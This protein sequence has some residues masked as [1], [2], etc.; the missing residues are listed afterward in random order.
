MNL[1]I[2]ST[3]I[4]LCGFTILK[5]DTY[6]I[7]FDVSMGKNDKVMGQHFEAL[8]KQFNNSDTKW[9]EW[10]SYEKSPPKNPDA[11][12][13]LLKETYNNYRQEIFNKHKMQTGPGH[14]N[15]RIPKIFHQ[16]WVGPNPFPE[17][18]KRWQKTW[19]SIPG[20]Q[21][22]L[23]TDK[24]VEN[25]PLIN[26]AAYNQETNF[27][28]RADILRLEI[29][30]R[31]GGVYIDTDFE[32][33]K[34]AMFNIL[35]SCYDFYCGLHPLDCKAVLL[36]NAL[37]GAIPG[38]PIIKACIDHIPFAV[39]SS[40][41]RAQQIMQRGPG[42]IS[43]MAMKNMN[44]GYRDIIFPAT[45][46]YPLGLFEMK[47]KPYSLMPFND[48]TLE[49]I[50][51]DVIKPETIAIHWWDGSWTLPSAKLQKPKSEAEKKS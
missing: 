7:D 30:Y 39:N 2:T 21:Y 26:Q 43:K 6:L 44:K 36:N 34:P 33:V 1:K 10:L 23:W 50:K 22:K 3:L 24:E 41:P 40:S 19:Q 31:E 47:N 13:S 15:D 28:A 46:F 4:I 48:E 20:W 51:N 35:N 42:L 27:G 32:C 12:Y 37:I 9:F 25:F 18:Y 45:F 14:C 5:A 17:K 8:E 11:A 29:L 38:H 16:I 49:K